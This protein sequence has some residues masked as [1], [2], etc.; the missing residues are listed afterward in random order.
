MDETKQTNGPKDQQEQT[1]KGKTS[2]N[3]IK[4]LDVSKQARI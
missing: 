1:H 2:K 3:M 4:S